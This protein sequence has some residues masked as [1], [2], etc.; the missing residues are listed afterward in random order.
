MVCKT[1]IL[2]NSENLSNNAP[3]GILTLSKDEHQIQGKIRLYNL[4]PLP[5]STKVGL[6]VNEKVHISPLTYKHNCYT[7]GIQENIDIEQSIYCALI[8]TANNKQVLLEGGSFNGFYF[9]D[10]PFDAILETKDE[11]L[12]QTINKAINDS[13]SC[14]NC[15]CANCEYKQHFYNNYSNNESQNISNN[16][17]SPSQHIKDDAYFNPPIQSNAPK[18]IFDDTI[19]SNIVDKLKN[20]IMDDLSQ[21]SYQFDDICNDIIGAK[22]VQNNNIVNSN[23][24][25]EPTNTPTYHEQHENLKVENQEQLEF[26]NDIIYQLDELLTHNPADELLNSIIPNSKFVKVESESSYV[27]GVIYENKMLKYIAY[28]VPASYNELPP[29]DLGQHYQWLPLNPRDVM[30][31]GY[32]MIFQEALNGNLVEINF[33]E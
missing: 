18:D 14:P 10:S 26:L 13:E 6:Y 27:L 25:T 31:D 11:Q 1:I 19:Q 16:E 21:S 7:F 4:A 28:G 30:S 2:S 20:E 32:F 12:E 17:N 5:Q 23:K 9:T 8:D 22:S 29:K 3:K 15:N 24:Y 33:E